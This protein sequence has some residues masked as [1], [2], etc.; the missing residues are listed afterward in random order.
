MNKI[1][2]AMLI[3]F[4]GISLSACGSSE[5]NTAG[6]KTV[7]VSASSSSK[8]K[9]KALP[10]GTPS[11]GNWRFTE[12]EFVVEATVTDDQIVVTFGN[13]NGMTLYWAGS[14]PA[15]LKDGD[16]VASK[17]DVEYM[18]NHASIS[19]AKTLSFVYDNETLTF[20]FAMMGQSKPVGL[21]K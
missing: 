21:E 12:G 3:V 17:R 11:A 4:L 16:I 19:E 10:E 15:N 2:I 7:S 13:D 1:I 14:F 18:T 8:P 5:D 9:I 6:N 20:D